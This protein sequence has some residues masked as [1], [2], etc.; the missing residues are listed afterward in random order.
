VSKLYKVY[1]Q[2]VRRIDSGELL[3]G[4][5]GPAC[6]TCAGPSRKRLVKSARAK[7]THAVSSPAL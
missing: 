1:L 5:P 4:F 2:L 7:E 3:G 6:R